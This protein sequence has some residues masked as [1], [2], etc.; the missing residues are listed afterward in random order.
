MGSKVFVESL[1]SRTLLSAHM[2]VQGQPLVLIPGAADL[3]PG[4]AVTIANN[5]TTP[6]RQDY[7]DFGPM[8]V[9]SGTSTRRYVIRNTGNTPLT[10][11]SLSIAG[12]NPGDFTLTQVPTGDIAA[13]KKGVVVVSFDPAA[14]G[15]RKA[16]LVIKSND[17]ALLKD[18]I[19]IKGQG[20]VTTESAHGVQWART[21]EGAGPK[22]AYNT[23]INVHYTGYMSNGVQFDSSAGGEPLTIAIADFTDPAITPQVIDG[24]NEGLKGMRPGEHR[25]LIIPSSLAYGVAGHNGAGIPP[26]STLIFETELVSIVGPFP[27]LTVFSGAGT[28][29]PSGTT[30]ASATLGTTFGKTT[31]G[32]TI[33]RTFLLKTTDVENSGLDLNTIDFADDDAPFSWNAGTYDSALGGWPVTITYYAMA[34]GN[35]DT[36]VTISSG[37]L[38][39]PRYTFAIHAKAIA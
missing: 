33:S 9:A 13:G 26:N 7:T 34:V 5:D 1:E 31:V 23:V 2:I 37:D 12:L 10:I 38:L 21:V 15:T 28:F 11:S 17:P 16:K 22:A 20:L 32:K 36:I 27:Y 25:T 6:S 18:K 19:A 29:I 30:T 35:A 4:K 39:H 8:S 3:S 24:W 14:A